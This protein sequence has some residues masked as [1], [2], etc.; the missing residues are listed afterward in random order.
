MK[1]DIFRNMIFKVK[2][3]CYITDLGYDRSVYFL[4]NKTLIYNL[5][6]C[7]YNDLPFRKIEEWVDGIIH[8]QQTKIWNKTCINALH[9][10]LATEPYRTQCMKHMSLL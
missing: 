5:K 6:Y 1:H 4:N 10:Y 8:L 9:N 2:L 3:K 7:L